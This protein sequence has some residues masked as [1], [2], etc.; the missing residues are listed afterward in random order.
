VKETFGVTEYSESI[1]KPVLN[2][3]VTKPVQD[4]PTDTPVDITSRMT[5]ALWKLQA[6]GLMAITFTSFFPKLI[7]YQEYAFFFLLAVSLA[8]AWV[9]RK[10]PWVGTPIDLPLLGLVGWVLCTIPFATDPAYSFSEWRKL[11]AQ[12]LV[13]YWAMFVLHRHRHVDLSRKIFWVV[14]LGS[15]V[16]S[17]FALVDFVLRGGT[18]R[19]RFVRA[20]APYSDYNWLTTYLVM[21]IPILIGWIVI[22]RTSRVRA[23]AILALVMAGIAQVATYTRAGWVAHF[24]QAVGFGLLAGRRRLVMW[25]LVSAVVMGGGLFAISEIG[26]QRSTIDPWTLS[27]R[28]KTWNLG[29]QQVVQHPFV[30]VGYGNDTFVKVFKAQVDADKD[31]GEEEKVLS[32]LHNTFAMVLM[33][34]GVPAIILFAWIFVR[35]VSTLSRQ[36][37]LSMAT[38]TQGLLVAVVVVT[39]GFATRNLFDYMFAG[40]LAHLFWIIVAAGLCSVKPQFSTEARAQGLS[41]DGAAQIER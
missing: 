8:L 17:G 35:I 27:A 40:S 20:A 41:S 23:I 2:T 37:R 11:L 21:V 31:K 34:S 13:F 30:G 25:V 12:V 15:L 10:T 24:V 18:W 33:G 9:E 1:V 32:G 22:H 26:Y 38:E 6:Y 28:V 19:D 4:V 29:F 36:W 39:I 3:E 7:H 5:G 16:L 14:A